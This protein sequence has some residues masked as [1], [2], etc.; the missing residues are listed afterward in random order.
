MDV[1]TNQNL[2]ASKFH[3]SPNVIIASSKAIYL[4]FAVLYLQCIVSSHMCSLAYSTPG[5]QTTMNRCLG[6]TRRILHDIPRTL[7]NICGILDYIPRTLSDTHSTLSN[8]HRTLRKAPRTL[9][10]AL[11]PLSKA[12]RPLSKAPR[13]LQ[14]APWTLNK[15]PRTPS[16]TPR[17]LSY[18]PRTPTASHENEVSMSSSQKSS[19]CIPF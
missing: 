5:P 7:S 16:N 18:T 8:T 17:T 6:N 10:K 15:A 14:K 2:S 3:R 4:S 1:S 13:P 19:T 11:R 12:L 9:S